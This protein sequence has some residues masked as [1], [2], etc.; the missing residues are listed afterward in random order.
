MLDYKK[1]FIEFIADEGILKFG[2]FTLKSGRISPYFFNMGECKT[3]AGL[4]KLATYYAATIAENID[5]YNSVLFGP[6]YKGIPLMATAAIKLAENHNI[7][8]PICYNRKEAKDHGE[9]GS[10][11]GA[12]INENTNVIL[13]DD[14]ITAGTAIGESKQILKANGNGKLSSVI[15]ALDRCEVRTEGA[16]LK[17]MQEIEEENNIKIYP[18]VNIYEVLEHLY[19]N[20][21][22]GKIYI[23]EKEKTSMENYLDKYGAKI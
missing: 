4:A 1:Q 19:N 23:G 20:K 11:I 10:L 2:E 6:A 3:G 21:I 13:I 9:G 22:N 17:S 12:K 18:I 7:D 16:S 8:I 5:C 14:V 15:I